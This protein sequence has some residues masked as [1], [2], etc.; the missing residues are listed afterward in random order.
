MYLENGR[1]RFYL[2]AVENSTVS[3]VCLHFLPTV[4]ALG[5]DFSL[6][7]DIGWVSH[8]QPARSPQQGLA[9]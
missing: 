8:V 6:H 4:L 3:L 9:S 5:P 2:K 1:T 7:Q